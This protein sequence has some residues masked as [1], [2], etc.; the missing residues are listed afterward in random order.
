MASDAHGRLK[1]IKSLGKVQESVILP[2]D[3]N[4]YYTESNIKKQQFPKGGIFISIYMELELVRAGWQVHFKLGAG[5]GGIRRV[6]KS[7][8]FRNSWNS[9]ELWSPRTYYYYYFSVLI[10]KPSTA[11]QVM[12]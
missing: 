5:A 10:T 3:L 7:K 8:L 4:F 6:I 2:N 11:N 12:S 9:G 1:E